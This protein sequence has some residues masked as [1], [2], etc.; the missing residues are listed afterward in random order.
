MILACV[1]AVMPQMVPPKWVPPDHLWQIMLLWNVHPDQVR[2]PL[3]VPPDHLWR[4]KWSPFA[5]DGPP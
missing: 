5:T 4:R 3:M 1:G 2:L